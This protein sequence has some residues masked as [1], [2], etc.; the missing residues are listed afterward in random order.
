VKATDI[1][2]KNATTYV[3]VFVQDLNDNPPK[4]SQNEYRHMVYAGFPEGTTI[5]TPFAYDDVDDER[6]EYIYSLS[7]GYPGYFDINGR[8]GEIKTTRKLNRVIKETVLDYTIAAFDSSDRRLGSRAK[9]VAKVIP[10]LPPP[11]QTPPVGPGV[12]PGLENVT[13][14]EGCPCCRV[15]C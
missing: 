6:S 5:A 3:S 4:F 9:F 2:G 7:G 14:P 15:F 12:G 10:W 13:I 1:D 8:T 11:S